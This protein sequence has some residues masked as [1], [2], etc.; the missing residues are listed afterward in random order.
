G[1]LE[2]PSVQPIVDEC[3]PVRQALRIRDAAAE[4]E[5]L[6]AGRNA[7]L[8]FPDDVPGAGIDLERAG[9][10]LDAGIRA[11]RTIVE[12]QNVAVRQGHGS[13]LTGERR[14]AHLPL[15]GPGLPV[16]SNERRNIAKA[17]QNVA[18]W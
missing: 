18:T 12:Q 8:I 2:E 13:V 11:E 6:A 7:V 9:K 10:R 17:Q 1:D 15:D 3:V 5:M 4:E 16:D 14:G